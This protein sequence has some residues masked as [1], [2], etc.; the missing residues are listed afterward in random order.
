MDMLTDHR[1]GNIRDVFNFIL[2]GIAIPF[3]IL[4]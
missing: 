3:E 4:I 1:Q 2:W